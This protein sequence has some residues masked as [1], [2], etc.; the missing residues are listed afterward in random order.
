VPDEGDDGD[1]AE[2]D[3]D[4]EVAAFARSMFI[5]DHLNY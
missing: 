3:A 4:E 5:L 1:P 2:M